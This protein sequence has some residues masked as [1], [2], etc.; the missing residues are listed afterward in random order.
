MLKELLII[1]G[2][3]FLIICAPTQNAKFTL[4]RDDCDYVEPAIQEFNQ[5]TAEFWY[6][7]GNCCEENYLK[8]CECKKSSFRS[9][10]PPQTNAQKVPLES[11]QK[12][13][14]RHR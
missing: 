9:T 10:N 3:I 14:Y 8:F 7:S 2:F 1:L 4:P 5:N 6:Q 12:S 11:G 13:N